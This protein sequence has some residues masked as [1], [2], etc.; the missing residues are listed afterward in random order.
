MAMLGGSS[1]RYRSFR[2][3]SSGLAVLCRFGSRSTACAPPSSQG[4]AGKMMRL[5]LVAFGAALAPVAL[6]GFALAL[7]RAKQAG[8]IS[9]Y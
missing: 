8:T 7:R 3:G 2:T 9:E 5:A 6:A 4:K 1:S